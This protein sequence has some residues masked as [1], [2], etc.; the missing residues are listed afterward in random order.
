MIC[1]DDSIKLNNSGEILA[2]NFYSWWDRNIKICAVGFPA[3]R[4]W[5]HN[6]KHNLRL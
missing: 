1:L 3:G 4:D 5:T 2:T 6:S